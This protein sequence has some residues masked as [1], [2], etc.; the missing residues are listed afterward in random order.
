[1]RA[2]TRKVLIDGLWAGVIGYGAVVVVV[3]GIAPGASA[4]R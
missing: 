4:S 2:R 3:G 1:M